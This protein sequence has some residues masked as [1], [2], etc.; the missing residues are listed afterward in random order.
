[1]EPVGETVRAR[2]GRWT[3][4][5]EL[6]GTADGPAIHHRQVV[7]RVGDAVRFDEEVVIP[8]ELD[9]VARVGVV[10]TVPSALDELTWWGLGPG[11]SY[12]DRR[13]AARVGRWRT[14]VGDQR[15]P[16]VKPQEFGHHLDTSW[17]GLA[18]RR[19][20]VVVRGDRPLGFSALRHTAQDLAAAAHAHELVM[21]RDT[22]VHLDAAHRGLG[23]AACGP[24]TRPPFLVGSGRYRWTWWIAAIDPR[25]ASLPA[26]AAALV[27]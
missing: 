3:R 14:R 19:V 26:A 2:A 16:F 18:G 24:D 8:A 5:A 22:E 10:F 7:S 12:P 21:R 6:A 25:R 11:D 20:A 13:A 4:R 15:L 1:M 9:D 17:F 23:T 27:P